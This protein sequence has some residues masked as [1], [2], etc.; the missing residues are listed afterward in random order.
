MLKQNE[1]KEENLLLKRTRVMWFTKYSDLNR[2][3]IQ[4]KMKVFSPKI[5]KPASSKKVR[6]RNF[7]LQE[8]MCLLITKIL[9]VVKK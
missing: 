7:Y 9:K 5:V 6:A 4:N 1:K 8:A 3:K 2:G